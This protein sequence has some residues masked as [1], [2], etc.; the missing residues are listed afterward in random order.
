MHKYKCCMHESTFLLYFLRWKKVNFQSWKTKKITTERKRPLRSNNYNN[1]SSSQ[2][3]IFH[4]L[5]NIYKWKEKKKGKSTDIL[6]LSIVN[7]LK[8]LQDT[9]Q[10]GIFLK[11]N[12]LNQQ[13][14][15]PNRPLNRIE[16]SGYLSF[17]FFF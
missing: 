16:T 11:S 13:S 8:Y 5:P 9:I 3:S 15:W 10:F 7:E 6:F 12:Q 14:K 2:N 4:I 1:A 17:S